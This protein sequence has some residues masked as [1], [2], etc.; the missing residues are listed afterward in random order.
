M[1]KRDVDDIQDRRVT[2]ILVLALVLRHLLMRTSTH[3][4]D[5]VATLSLGDLDSC[6]AA[7]TELARVRQAHDPPHLWHPRPPS[8]PLPARYSGP[9]TPA[10]GARQGPH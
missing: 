10:P 4:A 2:P 9:V 8:A 7:A 1:E 3:R 6:D 5:P